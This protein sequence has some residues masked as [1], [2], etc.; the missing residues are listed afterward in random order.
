MKEYYHS[1]VDSEK[2][3]RFLQVIERCTSNNEN[4]DI[5]ILNAIQDLKENIEEIIE[6]IKF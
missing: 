3:M 1:L 5:D 4:M 2:L 6:E